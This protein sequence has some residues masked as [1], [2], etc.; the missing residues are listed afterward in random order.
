MKVGIYARTSTKKQ[1]I[2][3]QIAE[4]REFAIKMGWEVVEVYADKGRSGNSKKK[5]EFDRMMKDAKAKR[6][7][8]VLVF[9]LSRFG[10]SITQVLNSVQ[11]LEAAK[12]S[13]YSLKEGIRTDDQNPYAKLILSLF[14]ALAEIELQLIRERVS[15]GVEAAQER[16][17]QF[18]RKRKL[19]DQEIASAHLLMQDEGLSLR[20]AAKMLNIAPTT[21]SNAFERKTS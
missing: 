20:K 2:E 3:T 17:A 5:P 1:T 6:F 18:G 10:R 13:F 11:E 7:D 8:M 15:A 14:A 16:G 21:L 9:Q 19:T 12:V 4:A